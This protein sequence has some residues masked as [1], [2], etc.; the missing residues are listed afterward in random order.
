MYCDEIMHVQ[1]QITPVDCSLL[2]LVN[3][4]VKELLRR[5]NV[6]KRSV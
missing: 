2:T 1:L 5:R 3:V 6:L 4:L